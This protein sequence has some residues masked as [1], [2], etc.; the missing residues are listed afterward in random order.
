LTGSPK[1]NGSGPWLTMA[2]PPTDVSIICPFCVPSGVDVF[3][4]LESGIRSC[5]SSLPSGSI[6]LVVNTLCAKH[7]VARIRRAK[8]RSYFLQ[9]VIMQKRREKI[10]PYWPKPSCFRPLLRSNLYC[11]HGNS[12]IIHLINSYPFLRNL[13]LVP[14]SIRRD[15]RSP[16]HRIDNWPLHTGRAVTLQPLQL[17][18]NARPV[19]AF[20]VYHCRL[21]MAF[22]RSRIARHL[23]FSPP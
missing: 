16:L 2:A 21:P 15:G 17:H 12:P 20:E 4:S 19:R 3:T 18:T 23:T 10:P 13:H 9:H 7:T 11:R 5:Y 1:P 14:M 6:S 8:D 22:F